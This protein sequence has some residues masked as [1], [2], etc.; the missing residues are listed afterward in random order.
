MLTLRERPLVVMDTTMLDH[1]DLGSRALD[2]MVELKR[3]CRKYNGSFVLLWHNNRL[4]R[5][6][7]RRMYEAAL[8]A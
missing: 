8:D 2:A 7:D 5:A 3:T 1:L 6:R 4:Q